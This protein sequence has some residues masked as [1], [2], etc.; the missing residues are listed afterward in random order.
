MS[1]LV[2]KVSWFE[3]LLRLILNA[4]A[5]SDVV[6]DV[7]FDVL[8]DVASDAVTDFATDVVAM[9]PLTLLLSVISHAAKGDVLEV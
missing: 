5:A 2:L 4:Y 9:L 8:A 6:A 7:A 1:A 3:S